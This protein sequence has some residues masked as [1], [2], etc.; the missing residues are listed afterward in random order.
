MSSP[1]GNSPTWCSSGAGR[2]AC[3]SVCALVA[4]IGSA[5]NVFAQTADDDYRNAKKLYKLGRWKL[6]TEAFQA[7]VKKYERDPKIPF[8]RLYVGIGLENLNKYREAREVLRGFVKDYPKNANTHDAM[9]RVAECSFYLDD[10]KTAE[11]EFQAFLTAAPKH[12]FAEYALPYLADAQLRLGKPKEAAANFRSSL[13]RFGQGRMVGVSQLGLARAYQQLKQ[14]NDAIAAFQK[15]AARTSESLAPNAQ[16]ELAALYFEL[17]KYTESGKA[18]DAIESQFKDKPKLFPRARLDAG[19]AYYRAGDYQTARAR[20]QAASSEAT[21][22]AQANYWHGMSLKALADYAQAIKVLESE[23]K[24]DP[25]SKLAADVLYG[26]AGCERLSGKHASAHETYLEFVKRW[27]KHA[28]ADDSLHFAAETAFSAGKLD[29]AQKTIDRFEKEYAKSPLWP[30]QWILQGR[31]YAARGDK[32]NLD[33]AVARFGKVIAES[34]NAETRLL[35]RFYL[36]QTHRR[37]ND[38]RNALKALEPLVAE[39]KRLGKKSR[40]VNALIL[41]GR[42]ATALKRDAEA[43]ERMTEY[44]KLAPAGE[45]AVAAL[46]TRLSASARLGR[47]QNV[48]DDLTL[49]EKNHGDDARLP[50]TLHTIAE[51]AYAKKDWEWAIELFGRLVP[52]AQGTPLH[53]QALSGLAWS[54]FEKKDYGDS[55]ATFARIVKEHPQEPVLAPQAAY[56]YA[57]SLAKAGKTAESATAYANAFERFAPSG[58]AAAGSEKPGKPQYYAYRAGLAAARTWAKLKKRSEA[59]AAYEKLFKKFPRPEN[60]D[61]RLDEWALLNYNAGDYKRSDEIFRRLVRETPDSKLADNARYTLAESDLNAG[62]T[63]A[64]RKEFEAL[65][66]DEKSDAFVREIS[67][68]RL[69][70]IAVEQGR[71]KDVRDLADRF[72]KDFTKSAHR[73]YAAFNSAEACVRLNDLARAQASLL[74]L[75]NRDDKSPTAKAD[76][77]PRVWV[78][79]AEIAFRNKEY[80]K[81]T[82]TVAAMRKRFPKAELLYQADEVLGRSYKKQALFEKAREAFARVVADPKGKQTETAAKCQFLIAETYLMQEDH[83]NARKAY[84][85]VV[86]LYEYPTWQAPSLFMAGQCDEALKDWRGAV[87][88]Y[89]ALLKRF[90]KSPYAT[91]AEPRLEAVQK[92]L[93]LAGQPGKTM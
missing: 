24:R 87:K 53:V 14:Y 34:K 76:W 65:N 61:E 71:W 49:F 5:S 85:R 11:R 3:W 42:S 41:A 54:Q 8:A 32:A 18:F 9:Y 40:Y 29:A 78:L 48:R 10:L 63:D 73:D 86:T 38:H 17:G 90:A 69:I 83:K 58:K 26:W 89:Q 80:E 21:L 45:H 59:N 92:R 64:A 22:A 46:T 67:L 84:L 37:R 44:L 12:D 55:A 36:A 93:K 79:L 82:S 7:F 2:A 35:A 13:A 72:Q 74:P 68:Y 60:L 77:F 52:H 19:F 1:V 20:F 25:K 43:V 6:A 28:N 70:G 15:L 47:K 27:P 39:V 31:V 30:E 4:V 62:R 50:K 81:V 91:K 16:S 23:F 88:S 66:A 56:K 51:A 75:Q 33:R 57:E